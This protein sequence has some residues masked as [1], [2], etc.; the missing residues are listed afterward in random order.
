MN[1]LRMIYRKQED[2]SLPV[3]Y[4][5]QHNGKF[6]I[7]IDIFKLFPELH[8]ENKDL[9]TYRVFAVDTNPNYYG[10]VV[11]DWFSDGK[12]KVIS[13]G[14]ESFKELNDSEKTL[15]D[16]LG[17]ASTRRFHY[18]EKREYETKSYANDLIKIARHF[19]CGIISIDDVSMK[20][21][22]KKKGRRF[23]KSVN[24]DWLRK[25]FS[26]T[27]QKNAK[28]TGA[29]VIPTKTAF[30][31]VIGNFLFRQLG[32]PDMCLAAF[33]LSRRAYETRFLN[34]NSFESSKDEHIF[35]DINR[36]K[37]FFKNSCELFNINDENLS[38]KEIYYKYLKPKGSSY[39]VKLKD[40]TKNMRIKHYEKKMM[41]SY[42]N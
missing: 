7:Q 37:E 18:T 22:N 39:R 42:I 13:Y 21:S 5:F 31:S 10:W 4:N 34:L 2:K 8:I 35:P 14:V 28:L 26:D 33:E 29:K 17:R 16:K 41:T 12:F 6:C 36:Y 30:S 1:M 15:K 38:L 32:M 9:I 11:I 19:K 40:A 27:Y 20:S 23:N 24:N 25:K 3:T